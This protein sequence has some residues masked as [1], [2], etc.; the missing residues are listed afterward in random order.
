MYVGWLQISLDTAYWTLYNHITIWGSLAVFFILQFAYNY[1][2]QG[3]YIGTLVK[4]CL[5]FLTA[6]QSIRIKFIHKVV[7]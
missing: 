1:L 3:A 7:C 5:R 2:F 4:V 6:N